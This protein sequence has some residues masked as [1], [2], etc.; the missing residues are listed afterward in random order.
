MPGDATEL[1]N[2]AVLLVPT[3]TTVFLPRP[4]RVRIFT[5]NPDFENYRGPARIFLPPGKRYY[6]VRVRTADG[7]TDLELEVEF[8]PGKRYELSIVDDD[9]RVAFELFELHR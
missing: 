8:K 2:V 5:G 7:D 1:E 9:E 6:K 4:H 3:N